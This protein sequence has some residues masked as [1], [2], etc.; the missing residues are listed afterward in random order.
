MNDRATSTPQVAVR[1]EDTRVLVFKNHQLADARTTWR[2]VMK[3][4]VAAVAF[5]TLVA[6][7]ALAQS[8]GPHVGS[9]NIVPQADAANYLRGPLY[10]GHYRAFARVPGYRVRTRRSDDPDATPRE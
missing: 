7:P 3:M 10:R 2:C 6:S 8:Y 4:L 1:R 9:G 5:A